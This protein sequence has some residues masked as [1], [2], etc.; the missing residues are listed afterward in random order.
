M[1]KNLHL[2]EEYFTGDTDL[3]EAFYRPC[4]SEAVEYNRSVGYFRSSVYIV[5]GPDVI[6]FVKRGG[7]IRLVSSPFLTDDD[8]QS[9]DSGYKNKFDSAYCALNRDIDL[10][11]ENQSVVKNTEALATLISLGAMDVKL[12]F[13]AQGTRSLSREIGDFQ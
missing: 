1:L 7:K 11:L 10:L 4:L 6:N 3:V 2:Q 12:V 5:I 9:I 13:F 8:I